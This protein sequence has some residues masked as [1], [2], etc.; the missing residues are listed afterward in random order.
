[1]M[2]CIGVK[3][4]VGVLQNSR[5]TV[6]PKWPSFQYEDVEK[7]KLPVVSISIMI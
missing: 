7:G 6:D 3:A 5:Y 1:M 4:P 2:V